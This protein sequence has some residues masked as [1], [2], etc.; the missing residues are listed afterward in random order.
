[1]GT[2]ANI[3]YGS[4]AVAV[5]GVDVGYT[6]G[7]VQLRK[8]RE[9][10]DV[11]ADQARGVVAKHVALERMFVSTTLLEATLTNIIEVMSEPATNTAGSGDL[12]YGSPSPVC[13]EALL[14]LTG[15]A[16][17]SGTRTYTF[18]RAVSS[19]DTEIPI[20]SRTAVQA[21][22]ITW[23][24]LKDAAHGEKFGYHEDS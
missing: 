13:N 1:M 3:L 5:G 17:N 4:C 14:T 19:E 23:E 20:G 15:V 8:T 2:V 16:P 11:E 21:I 6:E 24:M 9:I 7:G 12:E 10:I 18:Y 22:P